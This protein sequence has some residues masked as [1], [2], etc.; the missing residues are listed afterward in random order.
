MS[1]NSDNNS[2]SGKSNRQGVFIGAYVPDELKVE[3]QKSAKSGFRTLSQEIN[4]ILTES[5]RLQKQNQT[6]IPA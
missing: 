3:L 2:K 4:R 6:S 1:N 5:V